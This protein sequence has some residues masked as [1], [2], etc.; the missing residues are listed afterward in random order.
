M[1]K[2]ESV[3]RTCCAL[4]LLFVVLFEPADSV[5]CRADSPEMDKARAE[6]SECTS[7]MCY[8]VDAQA[9]HTLRKQ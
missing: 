6:N 7:S 3:A 9:W 2:A 4:V 1:K 8:P 5:A